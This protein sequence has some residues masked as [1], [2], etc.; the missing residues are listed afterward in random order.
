MSASLAVEPFVN[1]PPALVN[2][3][4]YAPLVIRDAVI[5]YPASDYS[6]DGIQG[7][8]SVSIKVL[9]EEIS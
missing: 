4:P 3:L 7:L 1:Y 8:P 9:P 5:I 6:D 2:K